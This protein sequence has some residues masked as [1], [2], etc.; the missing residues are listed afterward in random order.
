MG[1]A[2]CAGDS[3]KWQNQ[4]GS[5]KGEALLSSQGNGMYSGVCVCVFLAF[6]CFSLLDRKLFVCPES[7]LA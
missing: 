2:P 7:I 3:G 4:K 5:G 6:V 1:S